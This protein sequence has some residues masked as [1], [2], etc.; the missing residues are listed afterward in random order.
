VL[1]NIFGFKGVRV[2]GRW[3]KLYNEKLHENEVDLNLPGQKG[4]E[5]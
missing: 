5:D 1:R 2:T 4:L 3:R